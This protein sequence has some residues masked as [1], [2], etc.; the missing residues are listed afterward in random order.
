[1]IGVLGNGR[2]S[3]IE[4]DCES[5]VGGSMFI[6]QYFAISVVFLLSSLAHLVIYRYV[7]RRRLYAY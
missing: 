4:S 6:A 2:D 5:A 7:H 3:C 1:M